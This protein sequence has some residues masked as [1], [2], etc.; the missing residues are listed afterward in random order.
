MLRLVRTN[1]PL[2]VVFLLLYAFVLRSYQ[3]MYPIEWTP[4][5]HH[6]I[7]DWIYGMIQP[8]SYSMSIVALVLVFVQAILVNYLVTSY[9]MTR[10]TTFY[11]ALIYI[12]LA[13]AIPE[14]L[15][16]SPV[17]MANTFLLIVIGQLFKWYKQREAAAH[18]FNVG[19]WIAIGSMFYF[20]FNVYYILGIVALT[21]MRAFRAN[22][23]LILTIGLLVPYFLVGVYQFWIGNLDVFLG[24][25]VFGNFAFFDWNY[26]NTSY[27]Y[28]KIGLFVLLILFVVMR[29]QGYF[30]KTS[31]QAQKNITVL[32]WSI[33]ISLLGLIFQKDVTVEI[34]L[35][36]SLPLSFFIALNLLDFSKEWMRE[37]LHLGILMLV[38]GFQYKDT[39]F[40][41]FLLE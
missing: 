15:Y 41:W 33:F 40:S 22:E 10:E 14:F 18:I 13:S 21:S 23:W 19:F 7:T 3:F 17:L 36:L 25:Y 5:G 30:F 39:V 26:L 31:I 2:A 1:Q 4:T 35:L 27:I 11:P 29:S 16:L 28:F 32:L 34:F 24:E 20:S 6:F 9:K 12:L 8:N 37:A 38:L